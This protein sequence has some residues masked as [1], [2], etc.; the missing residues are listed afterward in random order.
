MRVLVKQPDGTKWNGEELYR[1]YNNKKVAAQYG[2]PLSKGVVYVVKRDSDGTTA[3]IG[4]K[5]KCLI[6]YEEFPLIAL[7]D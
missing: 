3:V 1:G 5:D 4:K 2:I 7:L 6:I